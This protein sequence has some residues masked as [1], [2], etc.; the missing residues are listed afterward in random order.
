M[1]IVEIYTSPFCG[2]CSRAKSLLAGKGVEFEEFNVM[3]SPTKRS[4]M[5]ARAP[6][7]YTVPQIFID[8]THVGGCDELYA[9][10]Q[11]GKLDPMLDPSVAG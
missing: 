6:G 7:A 5:A 8:G 1:A 2:Y 10:D 9:L 11:Q 4:E 3:L